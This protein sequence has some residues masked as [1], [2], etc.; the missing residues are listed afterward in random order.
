MERRNLVGGNSN[1]R[2]EWHSHLG[3]QPGFVTYKAPGELMSNAPYL[4]L[5]KDMLVIIF[6]A[7]TSV[8]IKGCIALLE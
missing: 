2:P 1:L 5:G 4:M 3:H 8:K 7:R 6:A